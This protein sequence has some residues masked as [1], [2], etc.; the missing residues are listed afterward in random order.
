MSGTS[1]TLT[2]V[3]LAGL[4]LGY[5]H[6]GLALEFASPVSYPVGTS[7]ASVLWRAVRRLPWMKYKTKLAWLAMDCS[8]LVGGRFTCTQSQS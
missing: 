4:S 3:L 5:S 7:P 1:K 2:A 8:W 6:S